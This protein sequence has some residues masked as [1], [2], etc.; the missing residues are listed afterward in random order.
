M[1]LICWNVAG[2]ATTLPK[3]REHYGTLNSYLDR[4]G[5]DILCLQAR[6]ALRLLRAT[7]LVHA[8]AIGACSASGGEAACGQGGGG[9]ARLRR[10]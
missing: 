9:S 4:L 8:D 2:W 10:S 1:L 7:P 6:P 3:I 5:A